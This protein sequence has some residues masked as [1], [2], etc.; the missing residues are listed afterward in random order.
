MKRVNYWSVFARMPIDAKLFTLN[1]ALNI[2]IQHA[3]EFL[4]KIEQEIK[5]QE[6][7]L[8]LTHQK[9]KLENAQVQEIEQLKRLRIS[10]NRTKKTEGKWERLIRLRYFYEIQQLRQE[11]YGWRKISDYMSQ[12]HKKKIHFTTLQRAYEKISKQIN[13]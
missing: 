9:S 2:P 6:T 8:A 4:S 3:E 10:K 5:R 1:Q 11:N 12:N 7:L 13:S